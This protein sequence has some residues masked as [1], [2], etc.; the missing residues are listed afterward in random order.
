MVAEEAVSVIRQDARRRR[1]KVAVGS[2]DQAQVSAGGTSPEKV[3]KLLPAVVLGVVN[4]VV[5][6]IPH[7]IQDHGKLCSRS[8]G[9]I[10][11]N[12][13]ISRL[14]QFYQMPFRQV[15]FVTV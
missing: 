6:G 13:D 3:G 1:L 7:I 12:N 5:D 14:G 10:I 4:I 8:Q 15:L 9:I 2:R 11:G